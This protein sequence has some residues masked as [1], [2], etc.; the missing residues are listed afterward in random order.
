MKMSNPG[1]CASG[2]RGTA[3]IAAALEHNPTQ[4]RLQDPDQGD[5]TAHPALIRIIARRVPWPSLKERPDRSG[6]RPRWDALHEETGELL[7]AGTEYPLADAAHALTMRGVSGEALVTMRHEGSDHDSFVPMPLRAAAAA[8][9]K[10]AEHRA[11]GAALG[12]TGCEETGEDD[13]RVPRVSA[14]TQAA[15]LGGRARAP[16]AQ[17]VTLARSIDIDT[18]PAANGHSGVNASAATPLDVALGYVNRGWAPVPV[19]Y[20]KKGPV[21]TGWQHL[22]IDASTAGKYF[23]GGPQNVGVILGRASDGLTDVD[24]DCPEAVRIGGRFLPYT[25]SVFGRASKPR[26]HLLYV[27]DLAETKSVA[28]VEFKDP[29][30]GRMLLELRIGGGDKGAQTVFPGSTHETDERI[31]WAAWGDPERE[32]GEQLLTDCKRLAAAALLARHWGAPSAR[33]DH[34]MALLGVLLRSGWAV[35][36]AAQFV[37]AVTVAADGEEEPDQRLSEARSTADR[38][39]AGE[40]VFGF[41]KLAELVGEKV[42]R[43]PR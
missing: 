15:G 27:T 11:R 33:N 9:A 20:R 36:Q 41:P 28:T 34:R 2:A 18:G 12:F 26:S 43:R 40:T 19:P 1:A 29:V 37:G 35:E 6:L 21:L 5:R 10:R 25:N 3:V 8:G 30:D 17:A 39:A 7:V 23:N 31:E 14:E 16:V 38:L 4:A 32:D 13:A 22:R 24:L 42:V